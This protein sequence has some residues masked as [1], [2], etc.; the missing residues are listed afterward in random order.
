M[1]AVHNKTIEF[2]KDEKTNEYKDCFEDKLK[3]KLKGR[4]LDKV[5]VAQ[6]LASRIEE[7]TALDFSKDDEYINYLLEAIRFVIS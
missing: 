2:K 1:A 5:A 6:E 4:S 7:D 3:Q